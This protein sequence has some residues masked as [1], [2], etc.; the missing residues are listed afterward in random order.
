MVFEK[1]ESDFGCKTTLKVYPPLT[2]VTAEEMACVIEFEV[3]EL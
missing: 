1:Y 2:L 3:C